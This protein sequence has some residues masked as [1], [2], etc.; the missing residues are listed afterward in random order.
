[1]RNQFKTEL[2]I[3][4]V[5]ICNLNHSSTEQ[6]TS[7]W[8]GWGSQTRTAPSR[9]RATIESSVAHIFLTPPLLQLYS[10]WG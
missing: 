4:L 6:L 3:K 1:M 7:S 10:S 9:A 2:T 5:Q 8:R